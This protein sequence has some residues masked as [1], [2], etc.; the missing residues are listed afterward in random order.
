MYIH[1]VSM[2]WAT[3]MFEPC[4]EGAEMGVP[5]YHWNMG[6]AMPE[7]MSVWRSEEIPHVSVFVSKTI[8]TVL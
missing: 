7:K 2:Y 6:R 8:E 1:S 4:S 5:I 3:C